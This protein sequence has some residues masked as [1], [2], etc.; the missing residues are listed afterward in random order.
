MV[1]GLIDAN[2]EATAMLGFSL[3]L[4]YSNADVLAISMMLMSVCVCVCVGGDDGGKNMICRARKKIKLFPL[5][6]H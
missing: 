2:D 4:S 5:S 3:S 6:L 1:F